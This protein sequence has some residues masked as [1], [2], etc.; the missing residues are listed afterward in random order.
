MRPAHPR[1]GKVNV[2]VLGLGLALVVPL[3]I[4]FAVSFGND[5]RAVPSTL[6]GGTAPPFELVDLDG[7][8][9]TLESLRGTPIVLNFWST[10]CGP[11]KQEHGVLQEAQRRY[12]DVKFL[13]VIY[14]DE[15]A[16]CRV[17]LDRV[18]TSYDHLVDDAGRMAIDYGVAGVPETFFI[19]R[20]GRITYKHVGAVFPALMVEKLDA[21]RGTDG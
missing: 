2:V 18:G 3:L 10:W 5:P 15:P 8:R 19:D 12:P 9:W 14:Q 21:I 4:L 13:G 11:C 17:Y 7:E 16:K 6:E 20:A 1:R